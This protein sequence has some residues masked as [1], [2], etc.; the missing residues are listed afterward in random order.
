M[1][2]DY[3]SK[4][5]KPIS[6]NV[7]PYGLCLDLALICRCFALFVSPPEGIEQGL[8]KVFKLEK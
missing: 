1:L 4:K 5:Y 8:Q 7:E 2:M 6:G 3:S